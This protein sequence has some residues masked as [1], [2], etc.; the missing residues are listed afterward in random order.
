MNNDRPL[1]KGNLALRQ[2][3][4]WAIDR[5]A[6]IGNVGGFGSG[7][8]SVQ[9]LPPG[10]AGYRPC[11]TGAAPCYPINVTAATV[12]KAQALAK[13]HTGDGKAVLYT[14]NWW[15][16]SAAGP[17]LPVQPEADRPQRRAPPVARA[18]QIDAR[19]APVAR[20]S[21][22]PS[23]DWIA[24]Y[25]DPFDFINVL[26]SGDSLHASNNNNVAYFND[27]DLQQ[28]DALRLAARRV[29]RFTRTATLDVD[30]HEERSALG[31]RATFN[32]QIH[33]FR[34]H[35]L[36]HATTR[37]TRSTSRR[38]ASSNAAL[39][40][41]PA[42]E[43]CGPVGATRLPSSARIDASCSATSS[44]FALGRICS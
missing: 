22:S 39:S 43:R 9:V 17:D 30:Y 4:N 10:M 18:V 34:P 44:S 6:L 20:R 35:R 23:E 3:V 38:S 41:R 32:D 25:A 42:V 13:G 31:S 33:A 8:R 27:P 7:D 14:S 29:S 2:A 16:C 19:K 24:D 11:K 26:L 12:K 21:T 15:C 1:I 37:P 36:L 5:R 28:G 40:A